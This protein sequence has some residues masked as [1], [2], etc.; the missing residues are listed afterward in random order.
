MWTKDKEARKYFVENEYKHMVDTLHPS[1][2]FMYGKELD[3][4]KDDNVEY[5]ETFTRGRGGE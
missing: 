5:I 4:I 3:E 1:K 2:V